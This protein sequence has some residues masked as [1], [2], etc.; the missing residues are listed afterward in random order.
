MNGYVVYEIDANNIKIGE[1]YF[2]EKFSQAFEF[3]RKLFNL[4]ENFNSYGWNIVACNSKEFKQEMIK[5]YE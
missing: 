4:P 3:A 1:F 2:F 5:N